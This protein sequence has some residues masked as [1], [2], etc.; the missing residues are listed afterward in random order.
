MD[1]CY[2]VNRVFYCIV[3]SYRSKIWWTSRRCIWNILWSHCTCEFMS[4]PPPKKKI[5]IHS[6]TQSTP[7]RQQTKTAHSLTIESAIT[8]VTSRT[9]EDSSGLFLVAH[10]L[11]ILCI[12]QAQICSQVSG[13]LVCFDLYFNLILAGKNWL[14]Q[15]ALELL[16][17]NNV[18]FLKLVR[19]YSL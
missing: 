16:L 8:V 19:K 17:Q 9:L 4:P 13:V 12:F 15:A 1:A 3:C 18:W 2:L 14:W 7:P 11:L 6:H 5:K 10:E